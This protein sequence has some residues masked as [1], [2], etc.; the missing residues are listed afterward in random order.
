MTM[1]G[2]TMRSAV[3]IVL[4]GNLLLAFADGLKFYR[5]T[6]YHYT[7]NWF[8]YL[9]IRLVLIF[10]ADIIKTKCIFNQL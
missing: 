2:V 7:L 9:T 5:G 6:I 1:I 10:A 8:N 4:F 3:A